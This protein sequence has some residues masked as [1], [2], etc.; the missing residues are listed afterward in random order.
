M[1][2]KNNRLVWQGTAQRTQNRQTTD[3]SSP[4]GRLRRKLFEKQEEILTTA[5]SEEFGVDG[6]EVQ[7]YLHYNSMDELYCLGLFFWFQLKFKE[8]TVTLYRNVHGRSPLFPCLQFGN[9]LT[10]L[11]CSDNHLRGE[12]SVAL[13][14]PFNPNH[15]F[16]EAR[17]FCESY[18]SQLSV[19]L[20]KYCTTW[21]HKQG[22]NR[23]IF[24]EI[25]EDIH[26]KNL[27]HFYQQLPLFRED[28]KE[29][30]TRRMADYYDTHVELKLAPRVKSNTIRENGC[31]FSF[32][33]YLMK[34][35]G[36]LNGGNCEDFAFSV[37]SVRPMAKKRRT[38]YNTWVMETLERSEHVKEKL[39][40]RDKEVIRG[41]INR[42]EGCVTLHL[43]SLVEY[44][45]F[46]YGYFLTYSEK[47]G[48][49]NLFPQGKEYQAFVNTLK[50][51]QA[52]ERAGKTLE[53]DVLHFIS[54]I[55]FEKE[56]VAPSRMQAYLHESQDHQTFLFREYLH[57]H[58]L[59]EWGASE[60]RKTH[61][62]HLSP[63]M[64]A[65]SMTDALFHRLREG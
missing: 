39:T 34:N 1:V 5:L 60:E 54:Q 12:K 56:D 40:L 38:L 4:I 63:E 6:T 65:K 10:A 29:V 3:A 16:Q 49:K 46:L 9:L 7:F 8:E 17:T 52:R 24:G 27:D 47:K 37:D 31:D 32:A 20:E 57:S 2:R 11:R 55:D 18:S 14:E 48:K 21:D 22:E 35:Q 58:L 33:Q 64:E 53:E 30:V 44:L 26:F 51:N 43:Y 42:E 41:E 59:D 62:Y 19:V 28:W 36:D 15:T 61:H 25:Y 23:E 45:Y 50:P 13:L